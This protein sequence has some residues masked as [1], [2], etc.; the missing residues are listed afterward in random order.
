MQANPLL[1]AMM[2]TAR[3][4]GP[5]IPN[6]GEAEKVL[7]PPVEVIS[8]VK[9]YD[10]KI[11]AEYG[12]NTWD[13]NK[14]R[15]FLQQPAG[16]G[17]QYIFIKNARQF[18]DEN[19]ESN[20]KLDGL[21]PRLEVAVSTTLTIYSLLADIISDEDP[22]T[23]SLL[24][25]LVLYQYPS[26]NL[27]ADIFLNIRSG[28]FRYSNID[29]RVT[30]E[31]LTNI[32]SMIILTY[33][34]LGYE[35]SYFSFV[36]RGHPYVL[37]RKGTVPLKPNTFEPFSF[38]KLAPEKYLEITNAFNTNAIW[39]LRKSCLKPPYTDAVKMAGWKKQ[40]LFDA[41]KRSG[42]WKDVS[43][44]PRIIYGGGERRRMGIALKDIGMVQ[45]DPLHAVVKGLVNHPY[46][47][48]CYY[49]AL[50]RR[51]YQTVDYIDWPLLCQ[52]NAV[53]LEGI[54]SIAV[55][56]F[57]A[58]PAQVENASVT[59]ICQYVQQTAEKRRNLTKSLALESQAALEGFVQGPGSRWVQPQTLQRRG[60][61]GETITAPTDDYQLY[62]AV[63]RYC[64][65]P[66]V[67]KEDLVGYSQAL[68]IRSFL[69]DNVDRY[70][71]GDLCD[72]L[73]DFLLPKAQKY[74]SVL[75]DC[76]DP[77]ISVRHILNAA[78]IMELGGIFPEDVS[79]LTKEEACSIFA[80][81]IQ[82]LRERSRLTLAQ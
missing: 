15:P 24:A 64:Q 51:I 16:G 47:S 32:R 67:T 58:N 12:I 48:H 74:Y 2:D 50:Y 5:P 43:N 56:D 4:E 53:S 65:D 68:N 81:Y 73:L 3:R 1:A 41:I 42:L 27:A 54:R 28:I 80:R 66:Q 61:R 18:I 39:K 35:F 37:A 78:T 59:D 13:T 62:L 76:S 71:K 10:T 7:G 26:R 8:G 36:R 19:R 21:F 33:E 17:L 52:L 55:A 82:L 11:F 9:I 46:M 60:P 70:S 6:I 30:V 75:I 69:P 79:R 25:M 31:L 77:A 44:L 29:V 45:H 63:Q 22:N 49:E 72:Y 57:N 14:V 40:D 23:R 34:G 20:R 38:F